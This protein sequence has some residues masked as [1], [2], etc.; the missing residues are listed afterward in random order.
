[1]HAAPLDR[2]EMAGL[3]LR[4]H[5]AGL[6]V[7]RLPAFV[8]SRVRSRALRAAGVNLGEGSV[9]WDF[10][11]IVGTREGLTRLH[12]GSFCGFNAGVFF[13]LEDELFI[14][15]HVSVGHD[16]MF[17]THTWEQG[18]AFQR[19]GRPLR[20]PIRVHKGAWLGARV[21]VMPGVT[22]GEGAVIGASVVVEKDVPAN[23][24]VMGT[25]KISLAKWRTGS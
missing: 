5:A 17:L 1:M 20:A 11:T 22:I 7:G 10:P 13:D 15:D 14:D 6:L 3:N 4:L 9:F 18:S 24:L 25:Q 21:T 8:A 19:A 2:E 23:T 12:I 16:V